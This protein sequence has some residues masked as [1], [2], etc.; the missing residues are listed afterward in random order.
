MAWSSVRRSIVFLGYERWWVGGVQEALRPLTTWL[1]AVLP[2]TLTGTSR[3]R[4]GCRS[5]NFAH[6]GL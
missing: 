2:G 1:R 3:R 5:P 6:V 4:R